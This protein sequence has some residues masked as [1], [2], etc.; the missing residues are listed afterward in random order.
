MN[1]FRRFFTCV[2][3]FTDFIHVSFSYKS[4]FHT[5]LSG[6]CT[7]TFASMPLS[8][9]CPP[10]TVPSPSNLFSYCPITYLWPSFSCSLLFPSFSFLQSSSLLI[11]CPYHLNPLWSFPRSSRSPHVLLSAAVIILFLIPSNSVTP[12]FCD[13]QHACAFFAIRVYTDFIMQRNI[14]R[15]VIYLHRYDMMV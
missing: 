2:V 12:N 4:A 14:N 5:F 7:V 6:R 1:Y 11:T 9:T 3:N 15:L 13:I 8:H 10:T